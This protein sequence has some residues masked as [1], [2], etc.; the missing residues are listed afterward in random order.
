MSTSFP[1]IGLPGSTPAVK[2]GLPG[3]A[4]RTIALP[5]KQQQVTPLKSSDQRTTTSMPAS[6]ETRT[7]GMFPPS[8]S[9]YRGGPPVNG[10]KTVSGSLPGALPSAKTA[11]GSLPGALPSSQPAQSTDRQMPASVPTETT[12]VKTQVTVPQ[13]KAVAPQIKASASKA[14]KPLKMLPVTEQIAVKKG[15]TPKT[16]NRNW[17]PVPRDYI[18][19]RAIWRFDILTGRHIARLL[20]ISQDAARKRLDVLVKEGYVKKGKHAQLVYLLTD[21]SA[22][23]LFPDDKAMTVAKEPSIMSY[24]HLLITATIAIE[25][26]RGELTTAVTGGLLPT[27]PKTVVTEREIVTAE[28]I[29]DREELWSAWQSDCQAVL[30]DVR[31]PRTPYGVTRA[32][33][34]EHIKDADKDQQKLVVKELTSWDAQIVPDISDYWHG[35]PITTEREGF[36]GIAHLANSRNPSLVT[37]SEFN[38]RMANHRTERTPD[39]VVACPHIENE[40][41]GEITGGSIAIEV[42]LNL[43]PKK[44]FNIR[45]LLHLWEHP[46]LGGVVFVT[47]STLVQS[48]LIKVMEELASRYNAPFTMEQALS[49][50]TFVPPYLLNQDLDATGMLG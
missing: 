18:I 12:V 47:D 22:R 31:Y 23:L 40:E 36:A 7:T 9:E 3:S 42:E 16:R 35:R 28:G 21:S 10:R 34:F 19:L 46:L 48:G 8:R 20:D 24:K 14:P 39:L 29:R 4:E 2:P 33:I 38:N 50:F 17:K 30:S 27:G 11:S 45:N 26:E 13:P 1:Q 49:Y 37:T 5:S 41:T 25:I 15:K 43:K 6:R 44:G 32:Q